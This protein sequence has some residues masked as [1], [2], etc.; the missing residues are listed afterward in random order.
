MTGVHVGQEFMRQKLRRVKNATD[1]NE[2]GIL[3][4]HN[5]GSNEMPDSFPNDN[6]SNENCVG[7]ELN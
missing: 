3:F 5:S 2:D 6:E 1:G 4:H 7:F